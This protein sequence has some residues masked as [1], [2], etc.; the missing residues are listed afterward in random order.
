MAI[1]PLDIL[2][3]IDY[4]ITVIKREQNRW[5]EIHLKEIGHNKRGTLAQIQ[6]QNFKE[7]GYELWQQTK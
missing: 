6:N 4:N 3:T 1:L 7:R 2:G 5:K